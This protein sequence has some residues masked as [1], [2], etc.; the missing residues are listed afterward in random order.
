MKV[1]KHIKAV[2]FIFFTNHILPLQGIELRDQSHDH[3]SIAD[4][5]AGEYNI[6]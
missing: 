3:R 1:I 4:I 5:I 6:I 2:R